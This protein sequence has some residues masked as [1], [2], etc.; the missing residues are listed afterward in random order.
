MEPAGSSSWQNEVQEYVYEHGELDMVGAAS[1][2]AGGGGAPAGCRGPADPS[3]NR[4]PARVQAARHR[5]AGPSQHHGR[6][7]AAA[8]PAVQHAGAARGRPRGSSGEARGGVWRRPAAPAA[9]AVHQQRRPRG[10]LL[11]TAFA[12]AT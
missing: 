6:P 10:Q 9:P 8:A 3:S 12:A 2:P 11:I 1:G 7:C 4:H 5:P